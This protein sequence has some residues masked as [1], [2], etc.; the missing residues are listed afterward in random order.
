MTTEERIAALQAMIQELDISR[1]QAVLSAVVFRRAIQALL[2]DM[3]E[4]E[5]VRYRSILRELNEPPPVR[6]IES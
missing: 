2:D 5:R 3:L 1:G 6:R 4:R